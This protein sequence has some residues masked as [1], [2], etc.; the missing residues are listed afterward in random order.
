MECWSWACE[1]E[2]NVCR[3][4]P[5]ILKHNG[6]YFFLYDGQ[7]SI[8]T[9]SLMT[10]ASTP[11]R[12]LVPSGLQVCRSVNESSGLNMSEVFSFKSVSTFPDS[13]L[14]LQCHIQML[15]RPREFVMCHGCSL[16]SLSSYTSLPSPL[17]CFTWRGI[18]EPVGQLSE[19]FSYPRPM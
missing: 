4:Q 5:S 14:N 7:M 10:L 2:M 6:C 17:T 12:F 9:L 15:A 16:I 11:L 18:R 1:N 13:F 8:P 19:H 3:T